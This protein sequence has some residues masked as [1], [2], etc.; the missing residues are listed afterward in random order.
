MPIS[1][2]QTFDNLL[3]SSDDF[4]KNQYSIDLSD[5]GNN[6]YVGVSK[7]K[8]PCILIKTDEEISEEN[9]K[10]NFRLVVSI[11]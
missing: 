6:L 9:E 11:L 1:L 5:L 4:L 10:L 7:E 8:F 3:L 2:K